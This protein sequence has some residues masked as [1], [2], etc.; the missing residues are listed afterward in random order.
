MA[1]RLF[2]IICGLALV[3]W[4]AWMVSVQARNDYVYAE[5]DADQ[6]AA[7]PAEPV[8][9]DHAAYDAGWY[10]TAAEQD[11]PAEEYYDE[12]PSDDWGPAPGAE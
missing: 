9:E 11:L 4:I 5:I 12:P 1:D 7:A 10:D 3:G 2:R 6:A 8:S